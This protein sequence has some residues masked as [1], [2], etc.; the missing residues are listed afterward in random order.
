MELYILS[1]LNSIY[2]PSR[3]YWEK[4]YHLC[5]K[6]YLVSYWRKRNNLPPIAKKGETTCN[7]ELINYYSNK[8]HQHIFYYLIIVYSVLITYV[9]YSPK[10]KIKAKHCFFC[11]S[12]V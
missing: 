10:R 1:N 8:A 3:S 4:M 11:T 12:I 2:N 5:N 9:G 6:L 7:G